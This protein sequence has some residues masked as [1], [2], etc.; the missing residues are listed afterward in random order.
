MR[1]VRLWSIA[2][3]VLLMSACVSSKKVGQETKRMT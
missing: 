1:S 3:A 2:A